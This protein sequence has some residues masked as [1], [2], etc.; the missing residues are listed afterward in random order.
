MYAIRSYY[1]EKIII[2]KK[3]NSELINFLKDNTLLLMGIMS[4][5]SYNFV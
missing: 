3:T 1:A 4:A 2:R 5:G